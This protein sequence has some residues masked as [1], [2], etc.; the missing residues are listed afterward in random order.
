M[1]ADKDLPPGQ[2]AFDLAGDPCFHADDFVVSGSNEAAY[3]V[4]QSFPAWPARVLLIT[5][6]TGSGKSH[7][8]AIWAQRAQARILSASVL[9]AADLPSLV[10]GGAMVI[11]DAER[12]GAAE[13]ALFHLLNLARE[14]AAYALITARGWPANWGLRTPDLL[15][16][17]RQAPAVELGPPDEALVR[18]VLVKLFQDRQLKVDTSVV[19]YVALHID[20]SLDAA[21]GVV[22]AIDH[23]A[24]VRSRRITR[25]MAAE[26]LRRFAEV[27]SRG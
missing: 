8:A 17:L 13:T 20:R 22:A 2:L 19:D 7:L 26:V 11:E 1:S 3:W 21:R 10:A 15:S 23:E 24:M 9:I 25:A 27:G 4:I 16:R 12:V 18:A 6:P 5:G 14:E